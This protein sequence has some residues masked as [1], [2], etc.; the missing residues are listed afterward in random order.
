M[1]CQVYFILLGTP[2]IGCS[3]SF[4]TISVVLNFFFALLFVSAGSK[5]QI[6][7]NDDGN[8]ILDH[9]NI[10]VLMLVLPGL[11]GKEHHTSIPHLHL[12]HY[13]I[14]VLKVHVSQ[15]YHNAFLIR[16]LHHMLLSIISDIFKRYRYFKTHMCRL[17]LSCCLSIAFLLLGIKYIL[18][19]QFFAKTAYPYTKRKYKIL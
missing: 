15:W 9:D 12:L 2:Y 16:T 4:P 8:F 7:W 1:V 18:K 6:R 17:M 3:E 13:M 14:K 11:F 10:N 5:Y 19:K